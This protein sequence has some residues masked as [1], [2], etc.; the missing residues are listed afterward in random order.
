MVLYADDMS[1]IITDK[2][3]LKFKINLNEIFKH[4]NTLFS[5]NLLTLD[6]KKKNSI[7]GIS[8]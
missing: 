2:N 3:K 7:F 4:I 5:I 1:I 8:I 6:L